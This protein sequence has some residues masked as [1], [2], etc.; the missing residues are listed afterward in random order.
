MSEKKSGSGADISHR[1]S[2]F[3]A[4]RLDDR[5]G[6]LPNHA[7]R[8]IEALRPKFGIAEVVMESGAIQ[9]FVMAVVGTVVIVSVPTVITMPMSLVIAMGIYTFYRER[10]VAGS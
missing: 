3:Y 9:G 2:R 5:L 6:F 8:G 10:K 7:L 4:H 1:H